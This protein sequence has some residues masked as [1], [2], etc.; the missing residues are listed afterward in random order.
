MAFI[1]D[2]S[3][4]NIANTAL[5][6]SQSVGQAQSVRIMRQST[7]ID[8]D[9]MPGVQV[10]PRVWCDPEMKS[11]CFVIPG[12][13]GIIL[14]FLTALFTS[15]SIVREREQGT[16]ERTK[17]HCMGRWSMSWLETARCIERA[18][19]PPSVTQASRYTVWM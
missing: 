9:K 4:P 1:I 8:L 10:R 6:A 11:A 3:D 13:I 17:L 19:K 15:M 18:W 5:A 16:I 7:G 14:L 12:I 2:G